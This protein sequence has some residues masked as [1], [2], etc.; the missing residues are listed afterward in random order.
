MQPVIERTAT[1]AIFRLGSQTQPSVVP[2]HFAAVPYE[3]G[4]NMQPVLWA[5]VTRSSQRQCI[6]C[7]KTKMPLFACVIAWI[8]IVPAATTLRTHPE[9]KAERATSPEER[10]IGPKERVKFCCIYFWLF[11]FVAFDLLIRKSSQP[12]LHGERHLSCSSASPSCIV[13]VLLF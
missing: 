1:H 5:A 6:R 9:L 10:Q 13:L 2:S 4:C 8:Y 12:K 7:L 11:A 3:Q